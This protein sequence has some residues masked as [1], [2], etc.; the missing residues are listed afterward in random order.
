MVEETKREHRRRPWPNWAINF[1]ED[2]QTSTG[3]AIHELDV[4]LDLLEKG[5]L[6][7]AAIAASR[8]QRRIVEVNREV[9]RVRN[10]QGED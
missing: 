6:L 7:Q 1:L 3:T 5:Q 10:S 8:A 4:V 9:E 2:T